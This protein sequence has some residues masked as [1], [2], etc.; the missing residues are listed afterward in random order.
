MAG[1]RSEVVSAQLTFPWRLFPGTWHLTPTAS[2]LIVG[3]S[4]QSTGGFK[5]PEVTFRIASG[6]GPLFTVAHDATLTGNGT[7]GSPLGMA[8]PLNLTGSV[9]G[10]GSIITVTN[11]ASGTG[12]SGFST[13]GLGVRGESI[14]R[15]GVFGRSDS[16]FGVIGSSTDGVGVQGQST[17]GN[18]VIGK[19]AGGSGIVVATPSGVLGDSE[20]V[21]VRGVSNTGFGVLGTSNTSVGI[22]GIS[23]DN[24]GV[25][26][27]SQ[28][29]QGVVAVTGSG[30]GVRAFGNSGLAG[31]FDGD[32]QVT[33]LLSKGGGSFKIDHPLDPEKKYLYHS[34]VE[35]PDMMNIYNGNTVTNENGD[36]VVTLPDYFEALN[37]D[38][39]YQL[40]VIGEFAQ[41]VIAEKIKSNRFVIKTNLPNVEVSWQVT[42]VRRDPWANKHRIKVE[43]Q[44]SELER[45]YYLHPELY[46]Q[47]EELGVEWAHNPRLMRQMKEGREQM[48]QKKFES[49]DR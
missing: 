46:D 5:I 24:D 13:S 36:A 43:E 3:G 23:Q 6:P 28:T 21:G 14:L 35:S 22:R 16:S 39:R 18:G 47:S 1:I 48:K 12:V 42:G 19:Q 30:I 32:V 11:A 20:G 4:I 7:V 26:G 49:I 10:G 45:G 9:G 44:K 40:T 27:F 25:Q 8:I 38:F 41:A 34:F 31:K 29:G 37:S 2:K 17:N 15:P 33:G